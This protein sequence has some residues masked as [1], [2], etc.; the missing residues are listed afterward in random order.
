MGQASFEEEVVNVSMNTC[1]GT[2]VVGLQLEP[3]LLNNVESE[4]EPSTQMK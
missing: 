1:P 2:K 3:N 4:A